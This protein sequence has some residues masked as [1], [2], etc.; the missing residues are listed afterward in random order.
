V[1]ELCECPAM[2]N[3]VKKWVVEQRSKG[4]CI[5]G[6][7]LTARAKQCYDEVHPESEPEGFIPVCIKDRNDF[8][9]SR[10]WLEN[11]L[12]R[13]QLVMRRISS[14]GRDLPLDTLKRINLYFTEVC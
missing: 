12:R 5:D 7:V 3:L 4:C 8:K 14:T 13:R 6:N 9:F 11:F 10:G 1:V 2:E